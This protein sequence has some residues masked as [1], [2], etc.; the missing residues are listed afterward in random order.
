MSEDRNKSQD[1][2]PNLRFGLLIKQ[3]G[4]NLNIH[5]ENHGINLGDVVLILE[6]CLERIKSQ[7]KD[8]LKDAFGK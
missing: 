5:Y 3:T 8:A 4:E 1:S 7:Y 6:T 2:E